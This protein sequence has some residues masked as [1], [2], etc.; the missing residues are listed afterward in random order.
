MLREDGSM[1]LLGHLDELRIRMTRAMLALVAGAVVSTIFAKKVLEFLIAPLGDH[2]P[3][4][5]G[6][7]T[8]MVI[9]FKV[10][11][12]GGAALAMPMI[13]YQLLGFI[14]PGLTKE[15]RRYLWIV[16]PG[17]TA[18]FLAGAAF[19]YFVM[20]STA[21]PFLQNF[22]SDI[23]EPSWTIEKYVSLVTS[24]VFWV[25]VSFETPLIMG[26]LA[27]LGIV[28][29][30]M[31]IKFWRY[32]L[33]LIA[34][35]AAAVTPTVDPLNMVLVMLPLIALYGLGILLAALAYRERAK[36][37]RDEESEEAPSS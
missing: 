22:L 4:A 18:S 15:E 19:A 34:V 5:L 35:I 31:L 2:M 7:T 11:L 12:V 8:S 20:L 14:I 30:K 28:T 33:V 16:I 3:T 37:S 10:S 6:P 17:V 9:F 36:P 24:L 23:I 27:R 26:F 1:S 21:I 29:P 13:V 32:A 25:G